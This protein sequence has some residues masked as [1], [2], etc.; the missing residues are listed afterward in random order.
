MI[1]D[2]NDQTNFLRKLIPTDKK[3]SKLCRTFANTSSANLKF[4]KT[5]LL[6]I[7]KSRG[8]F[9]RLLETLMKV[10]LPLM[11]KA[12][13]LL[14]KSILIP[15]ESIAASRE[16]VEIHKKFQSFGSCDAWVFGLGTT[17]LIISNEEMKNILKINKSLKESDLLIRAASE[18]F[19][20]V[21]FLV[22]YSL[23]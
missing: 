9:G 6:K 14:A 20:Q 23:H 19:E 7:A 2:S 5:Q 11:K 10:G 13:K 17:S 1:F 12:L 3:V 4:S 18:K 21:G 15:L 8:F 22:C 16:D